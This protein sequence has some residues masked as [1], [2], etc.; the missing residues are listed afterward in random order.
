MQA[1]AFLQDLYSHA[2]A[3][4]QRGCERLLEF[5]QQADVQEAKPVRLLFN[6]YPS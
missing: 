2:V 6:I 3:L 1:S 5:I 4:R